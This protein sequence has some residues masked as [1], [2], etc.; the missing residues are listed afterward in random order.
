MNA[1]INKA[2]FAALNI[3]ALERMSAGSFKIIGDIPNWLQRFN[4]QNLISDTDKF[5]PHNHIP[6]LENFLIDAEE[7]WLQNSELKLKSGLW[8][9]IDVNGKEYQFEAYALCVNSQKILLIKLLTDPFENNKYI[10]QKAR[11]NNLNYQKIL[12]ENQK[13]EIL[14]HC[15][16]HDIAGQLSAINCCLALLEFENLT[17]KGKEYLEVARKQS[18]NQEMLIRQILDVFSVEVM[19]LENFTVESE[20]LPNILSSAQDVFELLNPSFTLNN[21]QLQLSADIDRQADWKVIGDKSRLDRVISNLVENAYRHS[22]PQSTVTINLQPDGEYV[23]LSVDDEGSGVP[24]EMV[25]TLFK[26]FSQGKYK[27][28]KAGLGLYFCRITI[29]RWGGTIGYLPRAKGGSR[30]WFRLP[31]P[32]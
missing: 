25:D 12:K 23:L 27:S 17:P 9:E 16:V 3:L 2:L 24:P 31:R 30:F 8:N 5:L 4:L 32:V 11:E 6:F 29:E 20:M 21:I 15:I 14:I 22:S 28:G 18:L 19:S 26:K 7:F 13:K 1:S 10:I